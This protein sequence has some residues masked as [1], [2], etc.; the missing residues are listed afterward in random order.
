MGLKKVENIQKYSGKRK[1]TDEENN[2][3]S[4]ENV[5]KIE[6]AKDEINEI[7]P[8]MQIDYDELP[9]GV[10]DFVG[11]AELQNRKTRPN[12]REN[13]KILKNKSKKLES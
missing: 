7:P 11:L 10:Y 3:N 5:E 1:M 2:I 12:L 8:I 4:K 6:D 9:D 13:E